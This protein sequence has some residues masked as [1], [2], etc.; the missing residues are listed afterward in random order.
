MYTQKDMTV[1]L[2]LAKSEKGRFR[3]LAP[4]LDDDGLWRVGSCVRRF[5]SLSTPNFRCCFR[6]LISLCY[7]LCVV[8][9]VIAMWLRME[10]CAA[11]RWKGTGQCEKVHCQ[12]WILLEVLTEKR[13]CPGVIQ[14]DPGSQVE[15]ARGKLENWWPTFGKSLNTLAGSKNFEWRL[16]PADSPWHQGKVFRRIGVAKLLWLSIGDNPLV[17][18]SSK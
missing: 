3:P 5:F 10:H 15:S 11:S 12:R 8:L 16:S 17:H 9:I 7:R 4:V 1:E 13:S 14:S 6:L 18:W 2:E